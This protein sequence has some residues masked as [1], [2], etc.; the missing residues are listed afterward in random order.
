MP[1]AYVCKKVLGRVSLHIGATLG[2]LGRGGIG[3]WVGP[4]ASMDGF[5][6]LTPT[7]IRSLDHPAPSKSPNRLRYPGP[8]CHYGSSRGYFTSWY[9]EVAS[10]LPGKFVLPLRLEICLLS[11][12]FGHCRKAL[13]KKLLML[14]F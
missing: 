3:G 11:V 8:Q 5:T 13:L 12:T 7:M 6:N 10:R 1:G 4:R 14:L 2:D 9:V